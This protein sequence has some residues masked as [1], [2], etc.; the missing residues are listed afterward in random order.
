MKE[1]GQMEDNRKGFGGQVSALPL[2]IRFRM[3]TLCACQREYIWRLGLASLAVESAISGLDYRFKLLH[4][5]QAAFVTKPLTLAKTR[6][7]L[8]RALVL[9]RRC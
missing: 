9:L 6:V 2:A 7:L 3:Q 1:G 8:L 5:A 4:T